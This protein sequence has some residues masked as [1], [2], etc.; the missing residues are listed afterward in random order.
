MNRYSFSFPPGRS[1]TTLSGMLLNAI[2]A[3]GTTSVT[4]TDKQEGKQAGGQAGHHTDIQGEKQTIRQASR[5]RRAGT[6]TAVGVK[7]PYRTVRL[8]TRPYHTVPSRPVP[9]HTIPYNTIRA[10]ASSMRS[11]FQQSPEWRLSVRRCMIK[12]PGAKCE[13]AKAQPKYTENKGSNKE[14]GS[15]S[16]R[17]GT[18]VGTCWVPGLLYQVSGTRCMHRLSISVSIGWHDVLDAIGSPPNHKI[19]SA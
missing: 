13:S 8:Y 7:Q 2:N 12:L 3:L 19:T 14:N 4:C 17:S 5:Q 9:Y 11:V 16:I 18:S 1:V 10:L 6:Q 15:Q